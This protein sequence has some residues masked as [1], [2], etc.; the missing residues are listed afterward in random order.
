MKKEKSKATKTK[1][2]QYL[3]YMSN[4]GERVYWF[5]MKRE[6]LEG[7]LV[8]MDEDF[9]ATVRLDDGSFIEYQC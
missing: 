1:K 5:N 3:D 8:K 9:L 6:R 7:V 2:L 4:I